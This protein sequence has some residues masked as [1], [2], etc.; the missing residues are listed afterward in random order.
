MRFLYIA[1][2]AAFAAGTIAAPVPEE[3]LS[4]NGSGDLSVGLPGV[5]VK[6]TSISDEISQLISDLEKL[7]PSLEKR[8]ASPEE[9]LSVSGD[10][11]VSV[12]GKFKRADIA[13]EITQLISDLEALLPS[14]EVSQLIS[15]LQALLASL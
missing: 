12:N 14:A 1:L 4:V 10:G 2:T 5:N 8:D 11:S 3:D 15:K 9:D 13:S 6:R 7:L